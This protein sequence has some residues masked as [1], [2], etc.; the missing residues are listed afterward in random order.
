MVK[1]KEAGVQDD[2]K[3]GHEGSFGAARVPLIAANIEDRSAGE[4]RP[5]HQHRIG[6]HDREPLEGDAGLG[7][8]VLVVSQNLQASSVEHPP[9]QYPIRRWIAAHGGLE[10]REQGRVVERVHRR[11]VGVVVVPFRQG[12]VPRYGEPVPVD[13]EVGRSVHGGRY[14]K[15]FEGGQGDQ[16]RG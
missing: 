2:Q 13:V 3:R 15:D 10:E 9:G 14:E 8:V 11:P 12:Q 16:H 1:K 7:W 4:G 6:Q 5:R